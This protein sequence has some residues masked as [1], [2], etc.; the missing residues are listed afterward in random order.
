MTFD[1]LTQRLDLVDGVA[2]APAEVVMAV[3]DGSLLVQI[4]QPI[5][6]VHLPAR[7]APWTVVS[8]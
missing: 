6:D 3:L 7:R 5:E 8:L 1:Q 2:H 4:S